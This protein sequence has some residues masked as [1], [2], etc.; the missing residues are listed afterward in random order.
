MYRIGFIDDDHSLIRDYEKRLNR[1]HIELMVAPDG[2]MD[3]IKEWIVV[4]EIKCVLIDYQLGMKYDFNGTELVTYLNDQLK[5]L[6]CMILT[7][8]PDDSVSE[9]RVVKNCIFDRSI[10]DS[11]VEFENFCSTLIQ[12]TKVFDEN[13]K[14]YQEEYQQLMDKKEK[15]G[16][17][18]QEEEDFVALYRILRSYGEVDDIPAEMLKSQLNSQLDSIL[19]KLDDMLKK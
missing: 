6:P 7:S 2:T 1:H 3:I 10:M 5:G 18:L 14:R 12:A 15:S 13:I 19:Q 16:L 9:N 4:N 11:N 17:D 8:Y